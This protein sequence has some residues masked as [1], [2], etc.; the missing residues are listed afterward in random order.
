MVDVDPN[1]GAHFGLSLEIGPVGD[2]RHVVEA[3]SALWT[4]TSPNIGGP[5]E[6]SE[7]IG[8]MQRRLL[9]GDQC[10]NP[11][12]RSY[13][14]LTI[15]TSF[16]SWPFGFYWIREDEKT[17]EEPSDWLTL[18]IPVSAMRSLL[19]FDGSWSVTTQ[20]WLAT[21][22]RALA[23]I[24]D[25]INCHIRL[26]GGAMG[27]ET[28]GCWRR[29]TPGRLRRA[30]QGYPPLAVLTAE[31]L[32]DRGG[33]VVAADLWQQLAPRL[34]PV[35]LPSGLLYAPPRPEAALTGV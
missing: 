5:W 16:P 24:A 18:G 13:G 32:D 7:Y 20:P 11:P 10:S 25:H 15:G 14:M 21:V 1:Y 33:L 26:A 8:D 23:D 31:V 30:H 3:W 34:E 19:S 22:C 29:P 12:R 28:S 27:E 17:V 2:D 9:I 4:C 6:A 35:T